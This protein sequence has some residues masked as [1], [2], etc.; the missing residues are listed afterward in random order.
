VI[1]SRCQYLDP[2]WYLLVLLSLQELTVL[3]TY[4]SSDTVPIVPTAIAYSWQNDDIAYAYAYN[5][6]IS[7]ALQYGFIVYK[8]VV[9]RP[10]TFQSERVCQS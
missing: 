9:H 5:F 10:I 6:I 3:E 4:P 8:Y 2:E 1:E 7:I